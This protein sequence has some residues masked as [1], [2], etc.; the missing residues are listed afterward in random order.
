M[1]W[2]PGGQGHN[3]CVLGEWRSW[4]AREKGS[5]EQCRPW[6]VLVVLGTLSLP[7]PEVRVH[8]VQGA[9]TAQ[10]SWS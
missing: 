6:L 8:E 5:E 1:P 7:G 2:G 4:G 3:L 9:G 10:T